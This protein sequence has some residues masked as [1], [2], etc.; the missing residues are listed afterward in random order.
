MSHKFHTGKAWRHFV[1]RRYSRDYWSKKRPLRRT[2]RRKRLGLICLSRLFVCVSI[3][4]GHFEPGE[5]RCVCGDN[6]AQNAASNHVADK[7][8]I[9]RHKAHEHR[10]AKND[11]DDLYGSTA[12][13]RNQQH[14]GEAQDSTGVTG[15]KAADIVAT[16]KGMKG[17]PTGASERWSR[18]RPPIWP[19]A[20]A[21]VP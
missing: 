10:S 8:I 15:R 3:V 7:M 4:Q 19:T 12:R 9:H 21:N 11:H 1:N 2:L 18:M 16:L 17:I 13:H 20:T 5:M 14:R 6:P